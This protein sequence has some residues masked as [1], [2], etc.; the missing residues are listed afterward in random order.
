MIAIATMVIT[1]ASMQAA[2]AAST[3]RQQFVACL[4]EA[5]AKANGDKMK[6]EAFGPF[7]RQSCAVQIG[8]F[9]QGLVSFDVKA[10]SPRKRA[11]SDADAQIDDYLVESSEKLHPDS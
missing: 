3:Q 11:E 6:P 4:R 7:A 1:A 2:A 10:G 9:K 5:V 8:T